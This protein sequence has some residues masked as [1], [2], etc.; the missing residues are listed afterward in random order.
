M[1]GKLKP[2]EPFGKVGHWHLGKIRDGAPTYLYPLCLFFQAGSLA[3]WADSFAT[4]A[5]HHHTILYL[6][7]VFFYHLEKR[8]Y[9]HAVR[10]P[11]AILFQ[12]AGQTMPQHVSLLGG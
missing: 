11:F 9:A 10:S 3:V 7:L 8:V 12:V 2:L 5:A 4:V 1:L 6:V